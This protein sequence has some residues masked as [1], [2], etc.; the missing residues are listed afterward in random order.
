MKRSFISTALMATMMTLTSTQA[1]S[2]S[3][4]YNIIGCKGGIQFK[5][6]DK[7]V[8]SL[9]SSCN[10]YSLE[11]KVPNLPEINIPKE[12]ELVS[13]DNLTATKIQDLN[14]YFGARSADAWCTTTQLISIESNGGFPANAIT[15]LSNL[16]TIEL[17]ADDC[18]WY[19]SI[20]LSEIKD[21]NKVES[22]VWNY[23]VGAKVDLSGMTSLKYLGFVDY[24][25]EMAEDD[26]IFSTGDPNDKN[27]IESLLTI[28]N[29][30]TGVL[31]GPIIVVD[32]TSNYTAEQ[33]TKILSNK[34][35]GYDARTASKPSYSGT[36]NSW[37]TYIGFESNPIEISY[38]LESGKTYVLVEEEGM[39]FNPDWGQGIIY[40]SNNAV[41]SDGVF[42]TIEAEAVNVPNE[43]TYSSVYA[44]K[45]T[46]DKTDT[47]RFFFGEGGRKTFALIDISNFS[48]ASFSVN[49]LS[50]NYDLST[51][52][53]IK[54][55]FKD[56]YSKSNTSLA[57]KT[58]F[59]PFYAGTLKAGEWNET[60][61]SGYKNIV[62]EY[63]V[64]LLAGKH[65][66]L[67]NSGQ[68]GESTSYRTDYNSS[69]DIAFSNVGSFGS[70]YEFDSWS[71]EY[72]YQYFSPTNDMTLTI[73][74]NIGEMNGLKIVPF[75]FGVFEI[76]TNQ[77]KETDRIKYHQ[78]LLS[79]DLKPTIA[80]EPSSELPDSGVTNTW[81][82]KYYN[83]NNQYFDLKLNSKKRYIILHGI[84]DSI[85]GRLSTSDGYS[86]PKIIK[87]DMITLFTNYNGWKNIFKYNVVEGSY[88]TIRYN[89]Y[90]GGYSNLLDNDPFYFG[91]FEVPNDYDATLENVIDDFA[92]ELYATNHFNL[93]LKTQEVA[94]NVF[95]RDF[96]YKQNKNIMTENHYHLNSDKY[97]AL[98]RYYELASGTAFTNLVAG[99]YGQKLKT[100]NGELYPDYYKLPRTTS[101][102]PYLQ[103]TVY[104]I[105]KGEV[106][107][108]KTMHYTGTYGTEG[109]L[110][111][112]MI[113]SDVPITEDI[114]L[115]KAFN[116]TK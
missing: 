61:V 16:K 86:N 110:K 87:S 102:F 31:S 85:S 53:G 75:H 8:D 104:T 106:A 111:H 95:D 51:Q 83:S 22:F 73:K 96:I 90:D 112:M 41:Y 59:E 78:S 38:A 5:L 99:N 56:A 33:I 113:E 62:V 89:L 63:T 43:W 26:F 69:N 37:N 12:D 18:N 94:F 39:S 70:L 84:T 13:C 25:S 93:S 115:D 100:S 47:F 72:D 10:T 81:T 97:Y 7:G 79:G 42:E 101:E 92:R 17:N 105:P 116:M 35:I 11:I 77:L 66:L 71:G 67:T 109:Y 45:F 91:V 30:A 98:V 29:Y 34:N 20:D 54:E 27:M 28:P 24:E 21:I 108:L 65:Y 49:S 50:S 15:A 55:F 3:K 107:D 76:P 114:I 58:I 88:D 32:D 60:K 6:K 74:N 36:L 46:P 9:G 57:N 82:T 48:T 103:Y 2:A 44:F 19:D 52:T 64:N 14:D 68:N 80:I 23:V 1:I 40:D 4:Y